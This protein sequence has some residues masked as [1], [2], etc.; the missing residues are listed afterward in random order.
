MKFLTELLPFQFFSL[1]ILFVRRCY[2]LLHFCFASDCNFFHTSGHIYHEKESVR[3]RGLMVVSYALAKS[4]FVFLWL[5]PLVNFFENCSCPYVMFFTRPIFCTSTSRSQFSI[6]VKFSFFFI[7]K[8]SC[9]FEVWF[10]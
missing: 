2:I 4:S 9:W 8:N 1:F 5:T 10:R 6:S 7:S 3:N